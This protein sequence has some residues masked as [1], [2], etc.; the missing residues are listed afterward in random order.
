MDGLM[1]GWVHRWLKD[2]KIDIVWMYGCMVGWI[3]IY[4]TIHLSSST[5]LYKHIWV[6][7]R[8]EDICDKSSKKGN[9]TTAKHR[10][11]NSCCVIIDR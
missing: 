6:I 8:D 9:H 10:E 5:F 4:A 7:G 1:D 11:T 3:S 2:R